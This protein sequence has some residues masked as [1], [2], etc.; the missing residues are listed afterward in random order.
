MAVT[1][2]SE[3]TT[4]KTMATN[5]RLH[6]VRPSAMPY[7]AFKALMIR[8][9]PLEAPSSAVSTLI[10]RRLPLASLT[11]SASVFRSNEAASPGSTRS[12]LS[13]SRDIT[14]GIGRRPRR[15]VKNKSV[16]RSANAK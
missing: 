5:R 13:M 9:M 4:V 12:A 10:E 15:V 6:Q 7:A 14:S 8:S 11:T 1:A 3:N 16:G 2:N